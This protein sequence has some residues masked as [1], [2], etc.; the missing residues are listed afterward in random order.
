MRKSF[1]RKN[2]FLWQLQNI[3][4]FKLSWNWFI[5]QMLRMS[6]ACRLLILAWIL[7]F[8]AKITGE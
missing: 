5:Q 2:T 1:S 6:A 3:V 8:V 4:L 7:D